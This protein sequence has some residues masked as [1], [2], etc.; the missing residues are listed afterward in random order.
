MSDISKEKLEEIIEIAFQAGEDWGTIYYTW[1]E[2]TKVQ[3]KEKIDKAKAE[4][5]N[6]YG[7]E[8]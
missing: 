5:F 2:P 4:I 8:E 1:F 7:I 6:K 3:T